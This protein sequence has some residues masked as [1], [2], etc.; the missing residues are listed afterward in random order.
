[1]DGKKCWDWPG[2]VST[3]SLTVVRGSFHADVDQFAVG[4]AD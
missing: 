2:L 4:R 3:H 1:M